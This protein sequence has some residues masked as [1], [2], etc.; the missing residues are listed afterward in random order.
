MATLT[1]YGGIGTA[2]GTKF[3][4]EEQGY[5]AHFDLGLAYQPGR[6]YWD[7][8]VFLR[9]SSELRDLIA[10]GPAPAIEG[11]YRAECL[12]GTSTPPFF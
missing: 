11:I 4:V 8:R 2:T 3:A 10:M 12:S 9:Q 6:F 7:G 5:R 1:F